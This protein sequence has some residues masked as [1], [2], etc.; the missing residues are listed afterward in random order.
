MPTVLPPL[1]GTPPEAPPVA[2]TVEPPEPEPPVPTSLPPLLGTPPEAPP[3][4]LTV[5]PPEPEPPVLTSLPPLPVPPRDV[6]PP[7]ELPPVVLLL[8]QANV[9]SI[10]AGRMRKTELVRCIEGLLPYE[11]STIRQ[12]GSSPFGLGVVSVRWLATLR[13][14]CPDPRTQHPI[15][16]CSQDAWIVCLCCLPADFL[17]PNRGSQHR[18]SGRTKGIV[19]DDG[20]RALPTT[21]A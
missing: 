11:G 12:F 19:Q 17:V 10:A 9:N 6:A 15:G 8:E 3:V 14:P 2:L 20:G 1:L 4:A 5:E 16:N 18:S 7:L 13:L 21:A